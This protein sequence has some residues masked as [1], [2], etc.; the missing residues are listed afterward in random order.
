M[1]RASCSL[2]AMAPRALRWAVGVLALAHLALPQLDVSNNA[3]SCVNWE[4]RSAQPLPVCLPHRPPLRQCKDLTRMS[5]NHGVGFYIPDSACCTE[6]DESEIM[7]G[8]AAIM[9]R[10]QGGLNGRCLDIVQTLTCAFSCSP[11]QSTFVYTHALAPPPPPPLPPDTRVCV[12]PTCAADEVTGVGGIDG[13]GMAFSALSCDDVHHLRPGQSSIACSDPYCSSDECCEV[14]EPSCDDVV[15]DNTDIEYAT[16]G[17]GRHK[18]DDLSVLCDGECDD[19]D[20]CEANPTCGDTGAVARCE[21]TAAVSVL[22][23]SAACSAVTDLLD[24]SACAAVTGSVPFALDSLDDA[25]NTLT[26]ASG[27]PASELMP[28]Q[29]L[30]L[31]NATGQICAAA[32]TATDLLVIQVSGLVVTLGTDLSA[33]DADAST[34]CVVYRRG[35]C[36]YTAAISHLT[37]DDMVYDACGTGMSLTQNRSHVCQAEASRTL[38]TAVCQESDCC[39]RIYCSSYV[40]DVSYELKPTHAEIPPKGTETSLEVCCDRIM[41]SSYAC[42]TGYKLRENHASI[43]EEIGVITTNEMCCERQY[44][45]EWTCSSGFQ[46]KS[47]GRDIDPIMGVAISD[48]ECCDVT[49]A[50]VPGFEDCPLADTPSCVATCRQTCTAYSCPTGYQLKADKD[51]LPPLFVSPSTSECCDRVFCTSFEC[52]AG[53]LLSPNHA[54][55]PAAGVDTS[56]TEC[57]V[58]D[59]SG[60]PGTVPCPGG[61]C[62]AMPVQSDEVQLELSPCSFIPGMRDSCWDGSSCIPATVLTLQQAAFGAMFM[63]DETAAAGR[64]RMLDSGHRRLRSSALRHDETG[65]AAVE[66]AELRLESQLES[67]SVLLGLNVVPHARRMQSAPT[68]NALVCDRAD[69]CAYTE[70]CTATAAPICDAVVLDGVQATCTNAGDCS[71]T[72]ADGGTPE[73]CTATAAAVCGAVVLNGL[74]ETCISA[75]DCTFVE[76]CEPE[77]GD[78]CAALPLDGT[79]GSCSGPQPLCCVE[80]IV[81]RC[82]GNTDPSNDVVCSDPWTFNKGSD[83]IGNSV[84]ACCES[85]MCAGNANSE[86]DVTC[87]PGFASDPSVTRTQ[88]VNPQV[89]C[90]FQACSYWVE[91]NSCGAGTHA[92]PDALATATPA[93]NTPAT[94]CC[95]TDVTGKCSGNTDPSEDVECTDSW[96]FNKGSGTDGSDALTCCEAFMCSGNP[97]AG[98]GGGGGGGGD[99]EC[100]AGLALSSNSAAIVRTQADS[101]SECCVGSCAGWDADAAN[102]CGAGT[103]LVADAVAT[104]SGDTPETTCCAAD[105]TGK[106]SGNTDPSEDV[107]CGGNSWIY[108]KGSGVVGNDVASCCDTYTCSDN[109]DPSG[110]AVCPAGLALDPGGSAILRTQADSTS[111]CCVESCAAWGAGNECTAGTHL[112]ADAPATPSGGLC[113]YTAEVAAQDEGCSATDSEADQT[114]QDACSQAVLDGTDAEAEAACTDAGDCTYTPAVTGVAESCAALA[115][116]NCSATGIDG[117]PQA[118][119]SADMWFNRQAGRCV[120]T[121]Q[122]TGEQYESVAPTST[123]DRE[124]IDLTVCNAATSYED[125]APTATTDRHCALLTQCHATEQ[126]VSVASTPTTD[127]QCQNRVE[128]L[129]CRSFCDI[130]FSQCGDTLPEAERVADAVAFC[131]LLFLKDQIRV[132]DPAVDTFRHVAPPFNGIAVPHCLYIDTPPV[133]QTGMQTFRIFTDEDLV[134]VPVSVVDAEDDDKQVNVFATAA[135]AALVTLSMGWS[136]GVNSFVLS[137]SPHTQTGTTEVTVCGV[138]VNGGQ[139]CDSFELEV[140]PDQTPPQIE[141]TRQGAVMEDSTGMMMLRIIEIDRPPESVTVSATS[142]DDDLIPSSNVVVL[143]P[144]EE[145]C[146]TTDLP[147]P[148]EECRFLRLTPMPDMNGE[149]TLLIEADDS[150]YT[151]NTSFILTVGPSNDP[152]TI[153]STFEDVVVEED[154]TVYPITCLGIDDGDPVINSFTGGL[155]SG[156]LVLQIVVNIEDDAPPSNYLHRTTSRIQGDGVD[157]PFTFEMV[158]P[159]HA[160]GEA[161]VWVQLTDGEFIDRKEFHWT[162]LPVNDAPNMSFI[163]PI[164][165]DEDVP[166]V[167]PLPLVDV[168]NPMDQLRLT[169]VSTNQALLPTR[170]LSFNLANDTWFLS[171]NPLLNT[172]GFV[173]IRLSV[174]DGLL[175]QNVEFNFTVLAVNDVPVVSNIQQ[176]LNNTEV[177][178]T[179]YTLRDV[180]TPSDDFSLAVLRTLPPQ[181]GSLTDMMEYVLPCRTP[182]IY[183]E[184]T[185][186]ILV[187]LSAVRFGGNSESRFLTIEPNQVMSGPVTVS[188]F[189]DDL[190]NVT[191]FDL[192]YDLIS[193]TVDITVTLAGS[194]DSFGPGARAQAKDDFA[195]AAGVDASKVTILDVRAGSIILTVAISVDSPEAGNAIASELSRLASFGQLEIGGLAVESLELSV[196]GQTFEVAQWESMNDLW[197]GLAGAVVCLMV[198]MMAFARTFLVTEST[199]DELIDTLKAEIIEQQEEDGFLALKKDVEPKVY[200]PGEEPMYLECDIRHIIIW[201]GALYEGCQIAWIVVDADARAL[202]WREQSSAASGAL[203]TVATAMFDVHEDTLFELFT[204]L[205][206]IYAFVPGVWLGMTVLFVMLVGYA[207]MFQLAWNKH[208]LLPKLDRM[209]RRYW[210]IHKACANQLLLHRDELCGLLFDGVMY[211]PVLRTAFKMLSCRFDLPVDSTYNTRTEFRA[212]GPALYMVEDVEIVCWSGAHY[213]WALPALAL[214]LGFVYTTVRFTAELKGRPGGAMRFSARIET[215]RVITL[216]FVAA[217]SELASD[218]PRMLVWICLGASSLLLVQNVSFQPSLGRKGAELNATRSGLLAIIVYL[219]ACSIAMIEVGGVSPLLTGLFMGFAL[220]CC[221]VSTYVSRR[222][223]RY[224]RAKFTRHI[225]KALAG[226]ITETASLHHQGE[227]GGEV[228]ESHLK[229]FVHSSVD[230]LFLVLDSLEAERRAEAASALGEIALSDE[231][232]AK[233]LNIGGTDRLMDLLEDESAAVRVSAMLALA[234]L[235]CT[236]AGLNELG[237]PHIVPMLQDLLAKEEN[238]MVFGAV[239]RLLCTVMYCHV[240]KVRAE[241]MET[242]IGM[243][244]H[245]DDVARESAWSAIHKLGVQTDHPEAQDEVTARL[246][247]MLLQRKNSLEQR[248]HAARKLYDIVDDNT[249]DTSHIDEIAGVSKTLTDKQVNTVLGGVL[250]SNDPTLDDG[251]EGANLVRSCSQLLRLMA[252][253]HSDRVRGKIIATTIEALTS[254]ALEREGIETF[255][256]EIRKAARRIG[257]EQGVDLTQASAEEMG[258]FWR[259]VFRQYDDDGSGELDLEEFTDAMRRDAE[260][261]KHKVPDDGLQKL[262]NAIDIDGGGTI[263]SEEFSEFLNVPYQPEP[264]FTTLYQLVKTEGLQED[265]FTTIRKYM[266][267]EAKNNKEKILRREM[268]AV[269]LEELSGQ[270]GCIDQ[271]FGDMAALE[272]FIKQFQQE[273]NDKVASALAYVLINFASVEENLDKLFEAGIFDD[274]ASAIKG[275]SIAKTESLIIIVGG[276]VKKHASRASGPIVDI[277]CELIETEQWEDSREA[278]LAMMLNFC[279]LLPQFCKDALD[280]M[281]AL[282]E[283]GGSPTLQLPAIEVLGEI[284]G[285]RRC[286]RYVVETGAVNRV[287]GQLQRETALAVAR[288]MGLCL[289]IL[290][291][292]APPGE[293]VVIN[294]PSGTPSGGPS[295]RG[296]GGGRGL[297]RFKSLAKR[298]IEHKDMVSFVFATVMKQLSDGCRFP[299]VTLQQ[300]VASELKERALGFAILEKIRGQLRMQ[301][302]AEIALDPARRP[303][304]A[305]ALSIIAAEPLCRA[306]LQESRTVELICNDL[307]PYEFGFDR[308]A[309][310]AIARMGFESADV[311][312]DITEHLMDC[313]DSPQ[314][315]VREGACCTFGIMAILKATDRPK[316][317]LDLGP[318]NAPSSSSSRSLAA[319]G[320]SFDGNASMASLVSQTSAGGGSSSSSGGGEHVIGSVMGQGG[321][322]ALL[323]AVRDEEFDVGATACLALGNIANEGGAVGAHAVLEAVGKNGARGAAVLAS[324]MKHMDGGVRTNAAMALGALGSHTREGF[325]AVQEA[326]GLS[327]MVAGLG[328]KVVSV[329]TSLAFAIGQVVSGSASQLVTAPVVEAHDAKRRAEKAATALR[330]AQAF[331]TAVEAGDTSEEAEA[332]RR[333]RVVGFEKEDEE[334]SSDEE[335]MTGATNDNNAGL[336]GG[337]GAAAGD[338][339]SKGGKGGGGKGGGSWGSTRAVAPV[340][341]IPGTNAAVDALLRAARDDMPAMRAAA[342]GAVSTIFFPKEEDRWIR[343]VVATH[344]AGLRYRQGQRLADAEQGFNKA[345]LEMSAAKRVKLEALC[346]RARAVFVEG[347]KINF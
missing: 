278:G 118:V 250:A 295:P 25:A 264:A 317:L 49:C 246:I 334:D 160:F 301:D 110:D 120:D 209:V 185:N 19:S 337:G 269:A 258:E 231:G 312:D 207:T 158:P 296:G 345:A 240:P 142:S 112:K 190:E 123:S 216:F 27:S 1:G 339:E 239:S 280:K 28:G 341:V 119:C 179:Q 14:D 114:V 40:C 95:P 234:N 62:V 10:W 99:A 46:R 94:T 342:I 98:S 29:K 31:G 182:C 2:A 178:I 275:A 140:F 202:G 128:A 184:T 149:A 30:L 210:K 143:G 303:M 328:D 219:S 73:S 70:V 37:G 281:L 175:R 206:G 237:N 310:R 125:V 282:M 330:A 255:K 131:E 117:L 223:E 238:D 80:D 53:W 103:H 155:D 201:A 176:Q 274:L 61:G 5:L 67:A 101:S 260:I 268:A 172:F 168:D 276:V 104:V 230:M 267:I 72:A 148:V 74:P 81:G 236:D 76:T 277:F 320:T 290:A 199:H 92:L 300:L 83:A 57:C 247:Q 145:P 321:V 147:Y 17:L 106:C 146:N 289:C 314:W 36:S 97:E 86:D 9:Q 193:S 156:D 265:V 343:E 93:G 243:T 167:L 254:E 318:I 139:H 107:D 8:L 242:L 75:G 35:V 129:V 186:P 292:A 166:V 263:D 150:V 63:D 189:V 153:T 287:L 288:E 130:V 13:D 90:C 326:Y 22:A 108:N 244:S 60:V 311:C 174:T 138:D 12:S 340:V 134:Q 7:Q 144:Y 336:E 229:D 188:V 294:A 91:F 266:D 154:T 307:L 284:A 115:A 41:C 249:H 308:V 52:G 79:A 222:Y 259:D 235:A 181:E 218:R 135:N 56:T 34:N 105:V 335:P 327:A 133:V 347:G 137:M 33:G 344:A 6:E 329:R 197:G 21:E 195:S 141:M 315:A 136:Y 214:I 127:R 39:D 306:T 124:C 24:F 251:A 162:V 152:P 45:D 198:A 333:R 87:D 32:P 122:C 192:P 271:I 170:D 16:C 42:D 324:A 297:A 304:A 191:R 161:T 212:F 84:G 169:G 89:E 217:A 322:S 121:T 66:A 47:R 85:F 194:I 305:D 252:S 272:A 26:L 59:C 293:K 256:G 332:N 196:V 151:G 205:F 302:L 253:T 313:L 102:S 71:Y 11:Q 291:S 100:G 211:I 346:S 132:E 220:F 18:V 126:F 283:R 58:E 69:A 299:A 221:G 325:E 224:K 64:R 15:G 171:L 20:C 228:I 215:V 316:A 338:G 245:L 109:I 164:V 68:G 225:E 187:P 286:I 248:V 3:E 51:S 4:S 55:L 298:V 165:T 180:E 50:G 262:F 116:G 227:L 319:T 270:E 203:D 183:A 82:A 213:Q 54:A 177:L 232:N 88:D 273:Q 173:V 233:V 331:Q 44:C 226:G 309:C 113:M 261:P 163:P 23:D 43:P 279:D 200:P 285:L 78:F 77:H 157:V 204:Y 65:P 241:G 323:R 38:Q 48:D 208:G 111:E 159:Q 257:A 96:T